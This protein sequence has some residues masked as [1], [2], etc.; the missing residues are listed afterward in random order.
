MT[1]SGI[2]DI[3]IKS[4]KFNRR[5]SQRTAKRSTKKR[6]L[7]TYQERLKIFLDLTASR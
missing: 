6:D 7:E 2:A 1:V 4:R 5:M 3:K